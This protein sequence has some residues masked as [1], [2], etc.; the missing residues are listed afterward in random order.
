MTFLAALIVVACMV[1]YVMLYDEHWERGFLERRT[2]FLAT[3]PAI[4]DDEFVRRCAPGTRRETA[5]TVRRIVAE[6][7]G[8]PYDH[9]YPEQ[10]F[11]EDLG[12]D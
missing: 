8:I 2:R 12:A 9:V 11:V 1:M 5:L 7:L 3:W 6:Q 10:S 4:D